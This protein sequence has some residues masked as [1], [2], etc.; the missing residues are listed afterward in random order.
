MG[1]LQ[2]NGRSVLEPE[3]EGLQGGSLSFLEAIYVELR[4][5]LVHIFT[6]AVVPEVQ[7]EQFYATFAAAP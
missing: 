1:P 4:D 2:D 6:A 3:K 5:K 7:F